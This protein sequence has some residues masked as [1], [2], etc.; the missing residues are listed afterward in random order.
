MGKG[1]FEARALALPLWLSRYGE[2]LMVLLDRWRGL[3]CMVLLEPVGSCE[4]FLIW[5][6]LCILGGVEVD[7]RLCI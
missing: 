7:W 5:R 6:M 1:C 4:G 3:S 2:F